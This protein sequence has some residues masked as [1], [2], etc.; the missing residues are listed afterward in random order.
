MRQKFIEYKMCIK[1]QAAFFI[2][3]NIH[4]INIFIWYEYH[5][6]CQYYYGNLMPNKYLNMKK[7]ERGKNAAQDWKWSSICH[8]SALSDQDK[9]N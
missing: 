6:T 2:V 3:C 5:Y 4:I 7:A 8:S 9:L 1:L